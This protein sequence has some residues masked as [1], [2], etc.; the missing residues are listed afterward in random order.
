[1]TAT[2]LL[3]LYP[4]AWQERYGEEFLATVGDRPLRFQQI[5]DI[6][7]G[8]I[9][10]WFSSDVRQMTRAS[11]TQ[12]EVIMNRTLS[13]LCHGSSVRMTKRDSVI[14]AAVMIG[15]SLVFVLLG[16]LTKRSGMSQMSEFLLALSFPV[17]VMLSMPFTFMKG[18]PWKAQAVIC[19]GAIAILM[20]ISYLAVLL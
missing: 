3:R 13:A 12:G 14:G 5:I 17:S 2:Q 6:V 8:A 19:G 9:D 11:T 4:R 20:L 15:A 7:S 1:M 10:A 16:T 18:Q